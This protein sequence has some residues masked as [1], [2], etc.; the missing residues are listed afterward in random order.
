[1][2]RHKEELID[3]IADL[4]A[5]KEAGTVSDKKFKQD[6][7]DLKFQLSKTLEKLSA[8]RDGG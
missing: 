8:K 5:Q 7:K 3:A 2:V 1:L 6:L 4:E